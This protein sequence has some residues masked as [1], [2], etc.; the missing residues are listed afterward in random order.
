MLAG[1][2]LAKERPDYKA[3]KKPSMP[4]W[5]SRHRSFWPRWACLPG[6][7][8]TRTSFPAVSS[9]AWPLPAHW[10]CTRTS[11][12]ST[13]PPRAL[14]PELTGEVLRVLRDLA[15]RKTTMIIVTHENAFCP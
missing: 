6:Q 3:N 11:S 9:S 8:T 10:P 15:D 14:D 4:S 1:E 5:N 2:L 12:A 7:A 13:S